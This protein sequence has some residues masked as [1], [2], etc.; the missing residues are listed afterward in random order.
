MASNVAGGRGYAQ[1]KPEMAPWSRLTTTVSYNSANVSTGVFMGIL[2]ARAQIHLVQVNVETAFNAASTNVLT[3]GY[4]ASLN[5]I[6]AA[7][8]VDES[9][10]TTQAVTTG[11]SLEF[12][13]E[14]KIYAK[15]TQTGTAATA[16]KAR[17]SIYFS[18]TE[19]VAA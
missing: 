6:V 9:S 17:I 5:E 18:A 8:D 11:L 7:G 3:V 19:N 4:G 15:Y 10:A 1:F 12:S 14:Q 2:P 13:S 16:G